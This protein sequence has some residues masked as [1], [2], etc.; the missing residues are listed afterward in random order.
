LPAS[1]FET[2]FEK[3]VKKCVEAGMVGGQTQVIDG[4]FVEANASLDKLECKAVRQWELLRGEAKKGEVPTLISQPIPFSLVEK[5]VN[6]RKPDRSN[7]VYES[8]TDSDARLAQKAGK[9]F[10]LYY[11]SS[12]VVDTYHHVITHIQADY[13]D[14]RDSLHLL[15]IVEKVATRLKAYNL[16]IK[17]ILADGGFGSGINYAMLEAYQLMAYI[18]LQGSY[19]L[20]REGFTYDAIKDVYVCRQGKELIKQGIKIEK[21]FANAIYLAKQSECRVCPFKNV[22]CGNRGRK[23][24]VVTAY[25]NHYQ[26]MQQRLESRQGKRMKKRRMATVEPVFGSLLNYFGMKRA[27]ARGK[28]SAHKLMIMAACAYNLQKLLRGLY[29]PKAKSQIMI[30]QQANMLYFVFSLVVPQPQ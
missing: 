18:P 12:M 8:K 14:Q 25:R 11:L 3:V 24:L 13:A 16:F 7:A 5:V 10:R 27:N 29:H 21:G 22:C 30:L 6:P 17:N 4:A 9:P 20:V 19:H 1:V 23:K 26:R 15:P 28:Q 2:L